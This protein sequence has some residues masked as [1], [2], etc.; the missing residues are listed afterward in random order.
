[1]RTLAFFVTA[2]IG[3]T[4]P[5]AERAGYDSRGRIIALLSDGGEVEVYSNYVAVGQ[6]GKRTVL[7]ERQV[8]GGPRNQGQLK[9]WTGTYGTPQ[10]GRVT[11]HLPPTGPGEIGGADRSCAGA[12][13]R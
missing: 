10:S 8:R 3:L 1:M 5:A 4:L 7:L 11:V 12:P 13:S 2:S 6:D 9:S